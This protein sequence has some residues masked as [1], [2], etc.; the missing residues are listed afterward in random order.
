MARPRFIRQPRGYGV[1][2]LGIETYRYDEEIQ[3]MWSSYDADSY[4][5]WTLHLGFWMLDW[6]TK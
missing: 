2:H 4:R 6:T 3:T 5:V 1:F